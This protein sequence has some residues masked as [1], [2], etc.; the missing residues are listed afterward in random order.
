VAAVVP[1]EGYAIERVERF[2]E[3]A[4]GRMARRLVL[5]GSVDWDV[6]AD[7]GERR[8]ARA[9]RR[10]FRPDYALRV[11]AF[12]GDDLVG[13]SYGWQDG[14][15]R[16]YMALSAVAPDH[17][18]RGLYS[19]MVETIIM[20]TRAAGF[21]ELTS[22]HRP[23][24]HPVLIARLRLG[25]VITGYETSATFGG[26]VRLTLPLTATRRTV[27]GKRLGAPIRG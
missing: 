5:R 14:A 16:F 27:L 19:R 17:R 4:F 15:D 21:A 26:L 7:A 25:F 8:R 10:T 3:P 24:N 18:R 13:W 1:P 2:P 9:R 12:H 20:E 23:D 6:L 22:R 11:A